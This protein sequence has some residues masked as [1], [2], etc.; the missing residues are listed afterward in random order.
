MSALQSDRLAALLLIPSLLAA[1]VYAGSLGSAFVYD[2]RDLIV[3]N[4]WVHELDDLPSAFTRPMWSFRTSAPTNYYRP[5]PV[6]AYTLLWVA[7]GGRPWSFHLVS[8]L[9]HAGN[10]FLVTALLLRMTK[11]RT[12]ALAAGSLF[13][14]HPLASEAVAWISG[15]PE[16]MYAAA[17]LGFLHL[18]LRGHTVLAGGTL[19]AGLL[20]KET[21]LAALPLALLLPGPKRRV[22]PYLIP[23]AVGRVAVRRHAGVQ[24][25]P[26]GRRIRHQHQRP[27]WVAEPEPAQRLHHALGGDRVGDGDDQ[28]EDGRARVGQPLLGDPLVAVQRGAPQLRQVALHLAD[29]GAGGAP[30]RRHARL[31]LTEAHQ[32]AMDGQLAIGGGDAAVV[33]GVVRMPGHGRRHVLPRGVRGTQAGARRGPA[34]RR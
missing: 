25:R 23:V 16:L 9:L 2:D 21:A 1:V 32:V 29:R 28:V 30:H 34:A 7:S 27:G 19:L 24:R 22:L 17:V 26:R 15:F 5:L 20:S 13:A 11:E 6:A 8:V 31:G 14:V 18:H 33:L 4:P 3:Q 10:A 12:L